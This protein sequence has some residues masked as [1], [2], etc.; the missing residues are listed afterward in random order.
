MAGHQPRTASLQAPPH[1][2]PSACG[3]TGS[4]GAAGLGSRGGS[5]HA[6]IPSLSSPHGSAPAHWRPRQ[7]RGEV[8]GGGGRS[9]PRG[10]RCLSALHTAS[11]CS[12]WRAAALAAA[13]LGSRLGRRLLSTQAVP[14]PNRQPEVFYN[15]VRPQPHACALFSRPLGAGLR[16]L[17]ASVYPVKRGWSL[18]TP[19]LPAST[20]TPAP[21]LTA[22]VS[23]SSCNFGRVLVFVRLPP[24]VFRRRL[25]P[26]P[27][28]VFRPL[29]H[30]CV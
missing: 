13:G 19:S 28:L 20:L 27:S 8:V 10:P 24:P 22:P 12:M 7:G 3:R 6:P 18:R 15:Q 29:S 21:P 23:Y 26:L 4:L 17:W 11:C 14:A 30:P 25:S 1:P 9:E 16:P 2:L 5:E